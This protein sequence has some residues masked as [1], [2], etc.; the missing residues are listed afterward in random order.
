[1]TFG[2]LVTK[3]SKMRIKLL[4]G[5][6]FSFQI[7]LHRLDSVSMT[8][9]FS[10]TFREVSVGFG[11]RT[12]FAAGT[13][14][15]NRTFPCFCWW[16]RTIRRKGFAKISSCEINQTYFDSK[17]KRPSELAALVWITEPNPASII[18]GLSLSLF[19]SLTHLHTHS[20]PNNMF[21]KRVW[22]TKL[23]FSPGPAFDGKRVEYRM[24]NRWKI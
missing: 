20:L 14:I 15:Q 1:M 10:S 23:F 19:L 6:S 5:S 2:S 8:E 17:K 24:D 21:L 18:V 13:K 11:F 22:I 12:F 9:L 4:S 7:W 16:Q 3:F